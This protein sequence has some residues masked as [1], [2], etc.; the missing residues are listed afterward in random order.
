LRTALLEERLR[1]L[2]EAL[3]QRIVVAELVVAG[4]VAAIE[5]LERRDETDDEDAARWR[6]AVVEVSATVKGRPPDDLRVPVLFPRPRTRRFHDAPT[7]AEGQEGIW[8]LQ[9]AGAQESVR[10]KSDTA[11]F[12]ALH[13]LDFQAPSLLPR[14]HVLRL[15]HETVD[16]LGGQ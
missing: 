8:L 14:V 16:R 1:H 4:T 7:F 13:P 15:V 3:L 11:W 2:D 9:R 5:L 10:V 12:T 6:I